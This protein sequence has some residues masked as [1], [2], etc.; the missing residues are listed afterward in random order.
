[1]TTLWRGVRGT[2]ET[3]FSYSSALRFSRDKEH[4]VYVQTWM[5]ENAAELW[6]W[7]EAERNFYVCG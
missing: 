1:M 3:E 5:Q 2:K 4:K 7:L 6:R